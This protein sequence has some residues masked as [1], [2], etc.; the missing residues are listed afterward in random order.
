MWKRDKTLF[1]GQKDCKLSPENRELVACQIMTYSESKGQKIGTVC[2]RIELTTTVIK[3][4][5][6]VK[7]AKIQKGC[8]VVFQLY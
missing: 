2:E 7:W 6:I 1:R 5:K 8:C 3:F 4:Q